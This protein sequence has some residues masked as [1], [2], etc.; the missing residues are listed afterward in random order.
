MASFPLGG[1]NR[2]T[3]D[4]AI[5]APF[6]AICSLL[7]V[8]QSKM[9][10]FPLGGKNRNTKDDAI[11]APP[12]AICSLFTV[13]QS[14]MASFPLG[15][16]KQKY[17]RRCHLSSTFCHLFFVDCAA[18]KDGIFEPGRKNRNTKDDAI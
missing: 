6:F 14:K 9:A 17:E 18:I 4:D 11:L 5:L 15:G 7:T 3:K 2:N 16:K 1:K 8:L 10:S 13:L 12:F